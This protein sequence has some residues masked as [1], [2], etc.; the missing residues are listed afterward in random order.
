MTIGVSGASGHLGRSITAAL[1]QR[2]AKAI[3]GI[4]RTPDALGA[5]IEGRHGDYDAPETLAAA[6]AGLDTVI[7]IPT[8]DLTPGRRGVQNLAAID[9]AVAAGVEQI[10][11]VSSCGT[12]AVE[13]PGI[14]ASY[15]N[16]EQRLMRAAKRWSVVRM[17]YYAEAL[18]QEAAASIGHGALTGLDENKVAFV[19]RDDVARAVAGLVTS[20]GHDGAIY[21]ATGPVSFTGA[22]R[23]A[24]IAKLAGKPIAFVALPE[25]VLRGGLA[26]AGLPPPIVQ[27]V[28]S[29]QQGFATGGFD[30]VTGDVEKLS[31]L[32]PRTL[33]SIL[34]GSLAS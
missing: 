17:N 2:G 8:A 18:A 29:I 22:E 3:V 5:G 24:L 34:K 13:E 14:W 33:E 30:I 6:Y 21:N 31:G 10:V 9:A 28:V 4:S 32:A 11:F 16:A 27:A 20:D 7:L 1:T 15:Y 23:A 26:Q 12:R 19:A 25:E